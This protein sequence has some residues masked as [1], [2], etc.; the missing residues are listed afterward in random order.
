MVQ[1]TQVDHNQSSYY[2]S[3]IANRWLAVRL[4]FIGNLIT[5]AVAIFAM[6]SDSVR[7]SEVGLVISNALTVTQ[8]PNSTS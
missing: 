3:I 8:V 7:P 2:P 6:M 4:E 1:T 5:F